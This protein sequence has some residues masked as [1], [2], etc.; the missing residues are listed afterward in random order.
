ME[1]GAQ[2]GGK[3]LI[4]FRGRVRT[5]TTEVSTGCPITVLCSNYYI[6]IHNEQQT[7][8]AP[9]ERLIIIQ[10]TG[11]DPNV[12]LLLGQRRRRWANSKPTLGQHPMFSGIYT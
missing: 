2:I 3:G 11:A 1:R 12:G 6:V 4:S 7:V 8:I 10:N 5:N 9:I